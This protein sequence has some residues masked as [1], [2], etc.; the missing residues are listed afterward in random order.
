MQSPNVG[1]I[2]FLL[3]S[4]LLEELVVFTKFPMKV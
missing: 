4:Y 1:K 3:D 2:K